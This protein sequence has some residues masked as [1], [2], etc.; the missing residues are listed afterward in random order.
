[1]ACASGSRKSTTSVATCSNYT[2]VEGSRYPLQLRWRPLAAA[3][4]GAAASGAAGI[5]ARWPR[6]PVV[7]SE[8]TTAGVGPD[9]SC[10]AGQKRAAKPPIGEVSSLSRS[11]VCVTVGLS[12]ERGRVVDPPPLWWSGAPPLRLVGSCSRFS[13]GRK[14]ISVGASFVSGCQFGVLFVCMLASCLLRQ[15]SPRSSCSTV[16]VVVTLARAR[17][18][19]GGGVYAHFWL[20]TRASLGCAVRCFRGLLRW[21][22]LVVFIKE[23]GVFV[24]LRLQ[25]RRDARHRRPPPTPATNARHQRPPPT[26]ARSHDSSRNPRAMPGVVSACPIQTSTAHRGRIYRETPPCGVLEGFL[27]HLLRSTSDAEECGVKMALCF[28][29]TGSKPTGPP[30]PS[31]P[32]LLCL[33]GDKVPNNKET[34]KWRKPLLKWRKSLEPGRRVSST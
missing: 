11:S 18:V 17:L 9:F 31:K 25:L 15:V 29:A 10:A 28:P 24:R 3:E 21:R 14:K 8:A 33:L 16:F 26:P 5:P 13:L 6:R 2:Q 19:F 20:I 7:V 27:L 32:T 34:K 1:M 22:V 23:T 12:V 4:A 30:A